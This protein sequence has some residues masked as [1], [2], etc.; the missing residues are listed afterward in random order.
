MDKSP[1]FK[2][3]LRLSDTCEGVTAG[4]L[5]A[6]PKVVDISTAAACEGMT[7]ASLAASPNVVDIA[8]TA[9]D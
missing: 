4:S 2:V 9:V 3:D 7:A 8:T 1:N 5:A 6:S